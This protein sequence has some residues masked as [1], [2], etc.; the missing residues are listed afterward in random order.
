MNFA[1]NKDAFITKKITNTKHSNFDKELISKKLNL[2]SNSII[3][4]SLL[5]K[6]TTSSQ[7]NRNTSKIKKEVLKQAEIENENHH[8]QLVILPSNTPSQLLLKDFSAQPFVSKF[9]FSKNNIKSET[10]PSNQNIFTPREISRPKTKERAKSIHKKSG[11][12]MH[13]YGENIK[14]FKCTQKD[15]GKANSMM[16]NDNQLLNFQN[17]KSLKYNIMTTSESV[18][19]IISNQK[20]R[21][22]LDKNNVNSKKLSTMIQLSKNNYKYH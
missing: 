20:I 18:K 9:E 15:Q 17:M 21:S 11:D 7:I 2:P 10:S 8:K 22:Y 14:P 12:L 1:S 13:I 3:F 5:S 16:K 4:Q 19:N 6:D